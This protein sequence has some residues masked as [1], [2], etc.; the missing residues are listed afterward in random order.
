MVGEGDDVSAAAGDAIWLRWGA[1]RRLAHVT[2]LV[3]QG[4]AYALH[5]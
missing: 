2:E 5:G 4:H 1:A 3:R